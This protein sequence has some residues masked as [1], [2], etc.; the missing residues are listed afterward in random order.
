[1]RRVAQPMTGITQTAAVAVAAAP[2]PAPPVAANPANAA[3]IPSVAA[4]APSASAT[5]VQQQFFDMFM[6]AAPA[7]PNARE[8]HF[9]MIQKY[10]GWLKGQLDTAAAE[11]GYLRERLRTVEQEQGDILVSMDA[12]LGEQQQKKIDALKAK[13]R[14]ARLESVRPVAKKGKRPLAEE[15]DSLDEDGQDN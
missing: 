7:E 13:V 6:G 10:N 12:R 14:A 9:L 1:M 11:N 2:P 4:A 8:A 15:Q 3:V 5:V